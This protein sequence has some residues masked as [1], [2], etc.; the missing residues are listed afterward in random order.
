MPVTQEMLATELRE[1]RAA[2]ALGGP[3]ASRQRHVSRGKLLPRERI[4]RLLD[5][6]SPFLEVC[7]AGRRRTVREKHQGLE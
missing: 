2:A 6:G 1:R 5:E 4:A 3:E 7:A